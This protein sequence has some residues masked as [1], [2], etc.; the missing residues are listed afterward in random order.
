MAPPI[1]SL[2]RITLKL[3]AAPLFSDVTFTLTKGKKACLVGRNGSGKSTLLKII[4]DLA[5]ADSGTLFRHP[6]LRIGYLA[7]EPDLSG[8]ITVQAYVTAALPNDEQEQTHR[9]ERLL[10]DLDLVPDQNPQH[11][12]GGEKRRAALAHLLISAPDVML[13]DEPTNHLDLPRIQWLEDYLRNSQST[14]IV[15]SHDRMF[16]CAITDTILWL[17]RGTV[18]HLSR[19]FTEFD[20]WSDALLQEEE[21]RKAQLDKQISGETEWS[22]RGVKARQKRNVGRLH[23]L[24]QMRRDRADILART[25][26]IKFTSDDVPL[27]GRLVIEAKDVSITY[28]DQALFQPFSTRI[29]RGDRVGLIGANGSGKTTLL[30]ILM[31]MISPTSGIVRHGTKLHPVFLDQMRRTLDPE[32]TIRETLASSGGD[33]IDVRGTKRHIHGYMKD[34]LF[35]PHHM[36][37]P[38]KALSGGERNR[39]LLAWAFAQPSNILILDEPTND[40]DTETLEQLTDY[41]SSYD[42]TVLLVSHDRHFLD[43]VVTSSFVFEGN[44]ICEYPGGYSD[45]ERQSPFLSNFAHKS[46]AT[47]TPRKTQ[48]QKTRKPMRKLSYSDNRRLEELPVHMQA[49]RDAITLH[50]KELSRHDLYTTAPQ[51]FENVAQELEKQRQILASLEEEWLELE[52]KREAL[53]RATDDEVQ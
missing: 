30:H 6:G 24:Q 48:T 34:F 42:G 11:L 21:R 25:E 22:T 5:A 16:L 32:K 29:L 47:R 39:L 1:L 2:D 53:E 43:H 15:I 50:E 12:S 38:V 45:S 41:L 36:R 13:L 46:T 49:T 20:T 37:S 18:H 35:E 8:Y 33:F 31:N 10:F 4:A 19:G 26:R 7:Q 51:T 3:G 14:C 52:I 27:S 44:I 23:R 17:D 28:N 9:V 40:L